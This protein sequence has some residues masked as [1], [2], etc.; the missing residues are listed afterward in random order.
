MKATGWVV[1]VY[2]LLVFLG[3]IFGYVKAGSVPSL[4][5]GV[6]FAVILS[7]S[8]FAMFNGKKAGFFTAAA[9]I[10]F[11]IAFFIYRFALTAKFM[12]SGLMSLISLVVLVI[13]FF[14]RPNP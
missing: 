6:A 5:M 11:L 3:G 1:L 4:V 7:T 13:L 9:A 14:R 10:I 2:A 8:A 12:P